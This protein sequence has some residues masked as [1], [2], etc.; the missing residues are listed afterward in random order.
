[1]RYLLIFIVYQLITIA[2]L[3]G[4]G[5]ARAVVANSLLM[6]KLLVTSD[7]RRMRAPKLIPR[8]RFLLVFCSLFLFHRRIQLSAAL[9]RPFILLTFHR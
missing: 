1:M 4:L 9:I 8:N 7:R 3:A 6:K 5:C 2:K